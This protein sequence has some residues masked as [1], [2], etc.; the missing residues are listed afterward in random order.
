MEER[1]GPHPIPSKGLIQRRV[2]PLYQQEKPTKER[3]APYTSKRSQPGESHTLYQQE[4][5]TRRES[6]PI[7]TREMDQGESCTK[8]LRRP[9]HYTNKENIT[10]EVAP[11]TKL[12]QEGAVT[13]IRPREILEEE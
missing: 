12:K 8:Y 6:H 4:K 7:P 13:K 11:F 5:P 9:H 3:A 2:A 10:K 1:R